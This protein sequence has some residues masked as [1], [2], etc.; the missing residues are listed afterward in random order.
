MYFDTELELAG[1]Q[2]LL[3]DGKHKSPD[4]F[5][6]VDLLVNERLTRP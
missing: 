5:W 6:F 1:K 3:C 2:R 4:G